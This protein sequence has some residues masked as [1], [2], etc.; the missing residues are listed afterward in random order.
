MNRETGQ[1]LLQR[2]RDLRIHNRG[3]RPVEE[4]IHDILAMQRGRH[5][6][7]VR[8]RLVI[9]SAIQVV[10]VAR[11]ARVRDDEDDALE[12]VFVAVGAVEDRGIEGIFDVGGRGGGDA[13]ELEGDVV[14]KRGVGGDGRVGEDEALVFVVSDHDV[15]VFVVGALEEEFA[16]EVGGEEA[17]DNGAVGGGA[18]GGAEDLEGVGFEES[19]G[20]EL[21]G[22]FD[23]A[24]VQELEEGLE[25]VFLLGMAGHDLPSG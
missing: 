14:V 2:D 18:V 25:G 20:R 6:E 1:V 23:G 10:R 21:T 19:F 9:E 13:G 3:V 4:R 11:E 24:D 8:V 7:L 17:V 12:V 16:R 15:D 5:R 22:C